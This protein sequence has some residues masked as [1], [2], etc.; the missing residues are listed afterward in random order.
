M[1]IMIII[2]RNWPL[3]IFSIENSHL[4]RYQYLCM[5]I[6]LKRPNQDHVILF[7]KSSLGPAFS[8]PVFCKSFK[9]LIALL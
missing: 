2:N 4:N 9:L 6:K 3:K 8:D 5:I 1:L 7:S